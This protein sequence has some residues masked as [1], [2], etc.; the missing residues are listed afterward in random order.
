M[1]EM[2]T[3]IYKEQIQ[4]IRQNRT[5]I[6]VPVVCY[7]FMLRVYGCVFGSISLMSVY[8]CVR[9][10][11]SSRSI[12]RVPLSQTLPGYLITAH[13]LCVFLLYLAY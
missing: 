6:A 8:M 13:H 4:Q 12:A 1:Y 10:P 2:Y 11:L 7:P 3:E 5:F 9:T